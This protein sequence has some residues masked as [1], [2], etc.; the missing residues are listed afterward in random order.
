MIPDALG[1]LAEVKGWEIFNL[2]HAIDLGRINLVFL[3][4]H[5][6]DHQLHRENV[7][8]CEVCPEDALGLLTCVEQIGGHDKPAEG[9]GN[10]EELRCTKRATLVHSGA[11]QPAITSMKTMLACQSFMTVSPLNIAASYQ[12]VVLA[13]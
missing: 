7:C 4:T 13:A 9:L 3:R 1:C 12:S 10:W 11:A 5:V 8:G 6:F 2:G